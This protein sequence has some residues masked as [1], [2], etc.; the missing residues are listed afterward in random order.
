MA[1]YASIVPLIG[2]ETIAMQNVFGSRPEYILSYEGFENNDQ[3]LVEYYK[4]EVPYHLIQGDS[5][6][7]VESV[8]V[9]NTVCPCAGLSSLSV[10]SSSD[11]A[12]NDW[13]RTSARH[14]LGHLRPKVFW[15]ENAP[16]L[17][18]KMGE[19][20][21]RDLRNIGREN[22]YTFSIFK[23]KSILHGLSQVRDRTFYFFWKGEKVPQF[24]YIKR[25]HETIEDTIRSVKRDP[26]DPM[27]ILTSD[28]AP[29]QDPYYRYVLEEMESG[30]SHSA[31]QD[32]LEKSYD[33]KHYIEDNGVTY[34]KV[35]KWMSKHGYEKQA[36]RC[37]DMYH[38]LKSGGNIMR[39]GVNI[40][41]GYIGAFVGAYPMTLT[42]PDEDRF[43]TLRE[44][45]SIMKLP[46]DFI[47]QGGLKNINHICQNVP[48]TTAQDMAD[49]VL[50]YVDGRLDNQL[51]D[52]DY[53][54]QDNKSQTLS[55]EKESVQ[56]D[57]FMV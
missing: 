14:V 48:V 24:E 38:K 23:T 53:L 46:E 35:S 33:V 6:P 30:I 5:L 39:R 55:Y 29:S 42:H 57:A 41:K 43:L 3:H 7:Q 12:A 28:R 1:N 50:R 19:P 4:R 11:A 25:E 45:L 21:V 34:D 37:M 56:L 54:V 49:H 26:S 8:D 2:G 10:T 27:N 18:S 17:A 32:K 16:R 36:S 31:F 52:T 44:C 51:I 15:G 22:G 47:L 13:M 9:I 20:V 40:P